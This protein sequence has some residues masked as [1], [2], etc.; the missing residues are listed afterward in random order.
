MST[1]PTFESVYGQFLDDLKG[2]FP[3]FETALLHASSVPDVQPRFLDVWKPHIHLVSEASATVF[4]GAG[5]ELVPGFVMTRALWDS[6][7][8]G[9]HA[10]IWKY[11]STLLLLSA[12]S[13]TFQFNDI[14]GFSDDLK[15]MMGLLGADISGGF[16]GLFE[17]FSKFAETFGFPD[18]SGFAAGAGGAEGASKF[19]IPER[20]FKGHIAKIAQ[21]LVAEFK[22]EDFGLTPDLLESKD[23][24]AVFSF[25]QEIFTKKPEM[26]MTVAQKIA[27][28]IRTKFMRG[29]I[30]RDEIIKEAEEL[31]KEFSDNDMFSELF[32]SLK[33]AMTGSEK[34]TGNE[35]SARRREA[36]E[37]LRKKAAEKAAK[38]DAAAST[39]A[40]A[41]NTLVPTNTLVSDA[42][43]RADAAMT[44]LLLEEDAKK[45]TG[46]SR[47]RGR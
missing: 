20:L 25:L 37:R 18:I 40:T 22:P 15:R 30:K 7:S 8:E 12:Q 2:S 3:E 11:I 34:E 4:D 21:E 14:S 1:P 44:A 38:R 6:C 9:T 23:P 27:T 10:A 13:D 16:A 39:T 17:S 35:G 33:S 42:A 45:P 36:Q 41:T 31:M 5:I 46:K 24:Q 28:R 43:A 32:G 47:G 19:K 26:L 29:E